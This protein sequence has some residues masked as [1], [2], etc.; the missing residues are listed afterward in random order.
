MVTRLVALRSCIG[1][2]KNSWTIINDY[3]Y[4]TCFNTTANNLIVEATVSSVFLGALITRVQSV[5]IYNV[6]DVTRYPVGTQIAIIN[7]ANKSNW[8]IIEVDS[9]DGVNITVSLDPVQAGGRNVYQTGTYLYATEIVGFNNVTTRIEANESGQITSVECIELPTGNKE[10]DLLLIPQRGSDKNFIFSLENNVSRINTFSS[11]LIKGGTGYLY[12]NSFLEDV[13]YQPGSDP[14][15]ILNT[16][17]AIVLNPGLIDSGASISIGNTEMPVGNITQAMFDPVVSTYTGEFGNIQTI[18]QTYKIGRLNNQPVPSSVPDPE[19]WPSYI[20]RQTATFYQDVRYFI[21][22]PGSGYVVGGPYNTTGGSGTG[23]TVFILKTTSGGQVEKVKVNS[24]GT[25]YLKEDR[26]VISSGNNDCELKLKLPIGRELILVSQANI[27]PLLVFNPIIIDPGTGYTVGNNI[28]TS[29]PI[30]DGN[31]FGASMNLKVNILEVGTNGEILDLEIVQP[32]TDNTSYYQIDYN[33]IIE[34]GDT[35]AL[36]KLDK[37]IKASLMKFTNGGTNYTTKSNVSTFNQTQNNLATI[38]GLETTGA[39]ECE[40][41][42]YTPAD[43]SPPFWDLSRYQ[44]GDIIAFNQNG[45]ISA[46]AEITFIDLATQSISFNQLSF[47]VGYVQDVVSDYSY[48][49]TINL[50]QTAT[51]VDI[52]TDTNGTI[53][54]ASI[55]TLGTNTE[56]NDALIIEQTGSDHNAVIL[57]A[58]E[59]DVPAPWQPFENGRVATSTEWNEYKNVM[60]S[61]INLSQKQIIVDFKKMYPNFYNNSWYYYGDPDNKDPCTAG[62]QFQL[63]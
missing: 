28:P 41:F 52:T 29:C 35:N 47:G 33:L 60:K 55:N 32:E 57:I 58:S 54:H 22:K 19:G 1:K 20:H 50:S 31:T 26:I 49:P 44:V 10:G 25:G 11:K 36:I 8:A 16:N 40:V 15:F 12:N 18:K 56:Y 62:I 59:R 46:T 42:D 24:I 2:H 23:M 39:G 30:Y 7:D 43:L 53:T 63:F 45:N 9:N 27:A 5:S 61:A 13:Y 38:C 14:F 3:I 37:P 4:E 6:S 34:D 48:L 51:T 21:Q 17:D